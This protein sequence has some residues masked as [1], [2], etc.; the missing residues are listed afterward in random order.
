MDAGLRGG[1]SADPGVG[2]EAGARGS[3][4]RLTGER[5]QRLL[6]WTEEKRER[7]RFREGSREGSKE[8]RQDRGLL[9]PSW[10]NSGKVRRGGPSAELD[11]DREPWRSYLNK[12]RETGR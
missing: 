8:R 3:S 11:E 10:R 6:L 12:E 1:T 4:A 2:K 7:E 9:L 5:M